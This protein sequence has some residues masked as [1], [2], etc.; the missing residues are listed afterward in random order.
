MVTTL[1]QVAEEAHVSPATVSRIL[2]DKESNIRISEQTRQRVLA[3]VQRLG[4]RPDPAASRLAG[5][6]GFGLIGVIFPKYVLH[7]MNHPFYLNVLRGIATYCQDTSY[8]ILLIFAD[9]DCDDKTYRS[10]VKKP[11]DGFILTTVREGDTLAPGFQKDQIPFVH[12]GR[13]LDSPAGDTKCVDVDN[14][15]GARQAVEHLVQLGHRRIATITG[16]PGMAATQD[17]LAGYRDVLQEAGISGRRSWISEGN[18]DQAS[19]QQAMQRLLDS[20]PRPTAVF[21]ASDAMALG[22]L[23]AA[24]QRGLRVPDDVAIIGFDDIPETS[25]TSPPL[26]TVQQPVFELGQAAARLLIQL[27]TET[28]ERPPTRLAPQLIVRESTANLHDT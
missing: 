6:G 14:Y 24:T 22:A 28:G 7:V 11:A 23:Q 16:L 1:K 26:S 12:I 21:A 2:N 3:T 20:E 13:W 18:F 10:I 19:G 4:Y 8:D 9:L 5:K 17:R 15:A 25:R 27:L